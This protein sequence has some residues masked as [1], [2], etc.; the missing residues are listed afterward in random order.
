MA[1]F[2]EWASERTGWDEETG[3]P[4]IALFNNAVQV[5]S[6]MQGRP[7][8]TAEAARVFNVP[9]KRIIE[10]V[11]EHYWMFIE[12]HDDGSMTIEHEGE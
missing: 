6:V 9:E 3:A 12:R 4:G 5:W 1:D 10:A 2:A 7:T 11:D 8:T